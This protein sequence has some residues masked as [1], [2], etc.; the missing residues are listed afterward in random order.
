M[1]PPPPPIPNFLLSPHAFAR[2]PLEYRFLSPAEE[3]EMT[4]TQANCNAQWQSE[5]TIS[6]VQFEQ[7][8]AR[9]CFQSQPPICKVAPIPLLHLQG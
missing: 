2:H 6:E 9:N 8:I 4:A 7:D 5:E 3:M 1:S